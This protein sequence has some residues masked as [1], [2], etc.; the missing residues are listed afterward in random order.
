MNGQQ[1][2]AVMSI[3]GTHTHKKMQEDKNVICFSKPV[4][5]AF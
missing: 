2:R 5:I 3:L 1:P 4:V